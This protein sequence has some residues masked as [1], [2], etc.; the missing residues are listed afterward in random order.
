MWEFELFLGPV[1]VSE[2][3]HRVDLGAKQ[4]VEKHSEVY[5]FE[6]GFELRPVLLWYEVWQEWDVEGVWSGAC[7]SGVWRTERPKD[8]LVSRENEEFSLPKIPREELGSSMHKDIPKLLEREGG[9]WKKLIGNEASDT[10]VLQSISTVLVA[11]S[12]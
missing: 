7:C 5:V 11:I 10:F 1:E 12:M 3:E 4:L 6:M 8:R 9:G 2:S